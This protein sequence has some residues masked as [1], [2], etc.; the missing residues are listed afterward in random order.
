MLLINHTLTGVALGLTIDNPA[1]IVPTA[2][3]SHL[4][5]DTTPHFGPPQHWKFGFRAPWFLIVG[6]VDFALSIGITAMSLVIWPD[7]VVQIL[8][9]V[10]GADLPDFLYI[11]AILF[12]QA[13]VERVVP[14]YKR[15]LAFTNGIQWYEH[16][17]GLITEAIW[18]VLILTFLHSQ[19]PL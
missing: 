18:C 7:R 5:L 9:G 4:L 10:I 15:V 1:V 3:A 11:P 16:P 14:L 8:C 6:G 12:G 13:T 2:V 19:L 17:L